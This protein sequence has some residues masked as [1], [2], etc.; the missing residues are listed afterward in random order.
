MELDSDDPEVKLDLAR[1][2]ISMGD[3]N[4]ARLMLEEVIDSGNEK[5]A[6]EAREMMDEI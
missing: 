2:H 3:F 1:A 4:A 5:Q 6:R